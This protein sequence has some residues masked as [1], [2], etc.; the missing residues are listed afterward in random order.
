MGK[1]VGQVSTKADNLW[2]K[3]IRG[4]YLRGGD[5]RSHLPPYNASWAWRKIC[6]LRSTF[7]PGVENNNWKIIPNGDYTVVARYKWLSQS[8]R[9][10]CWQ[11]WD[12]GTLNI[13]KHAFICW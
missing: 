13:P 8:S 10:V 1:Y 7:S 5:F 6:H 3:W 11:V 12:W 9:K 4:I 2:V